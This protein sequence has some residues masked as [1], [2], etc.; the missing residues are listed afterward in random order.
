MGEKITGNVSQHMVLRAL[1]QSKW[2][3]ISFVSSGDRGVLGVVY[4]GNG[5]IKSF[6][7]SELQIIK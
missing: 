6:P 4:N 5:V 3:L 2:T 1:D 7:I